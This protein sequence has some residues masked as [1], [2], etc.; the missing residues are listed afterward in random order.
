MK[1]D[2]IVQARTG[3]TRLPCKVMMDLCGKPVLQQIVERIQYCRLVDR[4]IVATTELAQDDVIEQLCLR[5]G[6]HVFRGSPK[7][8]LDRYYNC[9]RR[10]NAEHVVRMTADNA[11]FDP[12]IVDQGIDYYFV[13]RKDYV[14][15]REGLPLGTAIEI[16]P[17]SALETAWTESAD[18]ASREHVT[19]YMYRHPDRF[20][21]DRVHAIGPRHDDLRLTMDTVP[22]YELV[23]RIYN[24]L[25]EKN[26][27]FTLEDVYLLLEKHPEWKALN[28]LIVQKT[29][30]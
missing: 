21:C 23:T 9:A 13:N 2:V 6:Y 28:A 20:V 7:D 16:F 5:R 1:A 17:F 27:R 18:P 14:Y 4:V 25:Y 26:P 24:E 3:S 11:L 8:V 22:D 10:Y 12:G 29:V 30:I 15:Y 19:A